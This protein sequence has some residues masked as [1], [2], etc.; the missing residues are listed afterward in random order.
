MADLKLL[1]PA[2][3]MLNQSWKQM[4]RAPTHLYA[5]FGNKNFY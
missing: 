2:L 3:H 4:T 1:S 5:C